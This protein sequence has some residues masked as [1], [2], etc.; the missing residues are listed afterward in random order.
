MYFIKQTLSGARVLYHEWHNFLSDVL[1][2]ITAQE[3]LDSNKESRS[4]DLTL[5]HKCTFSKAAQHIK[6]L[7][8]ERYVI[9]FAKGR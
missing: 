7:H 3:L 2:V 8:P 6:M 5:P 1:L 4:P 9:Y